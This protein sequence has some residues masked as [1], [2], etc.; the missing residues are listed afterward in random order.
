VKFTADRTIVGQSQVIAE[1][2]WVVSSSNTA[3]IIV[4][5]KVSI[6]KSNKIVKSTADCVNDL[7]ALIT[8]NANC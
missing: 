6:E 7:V 3:I 8:F 2:R 5:V 4:A 1:Q